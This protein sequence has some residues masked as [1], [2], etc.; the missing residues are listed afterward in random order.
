VEIVL[1]YLKLTMHNILIEHEAPVHVHHSANVVAHS[2]S[3]RSIPP[4]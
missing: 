2:S 1:Y 4:L 3:V